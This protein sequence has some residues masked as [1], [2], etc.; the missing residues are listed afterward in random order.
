MRLLVLSF[1]LAASSIATAFVVGEPLELPLPYSDLNALYTAPRTAPVQEPCGDYGELAPRRIVESTYY[2]FCAALAE[3][4][5]TGTVIGD[6]NY[7]L[8][9]DNKEVGQP[10]YGCSVGEKIGINRIPALCFVHN[11]APLNTVYGFSGFSY[12]GK[13]PFGGKPFVV[14]AGEELSKVS[15]RSLA[16][17]EN[18][19][20]TAYQQ[21]DFQ[22]EGIE[23]TSSIS[24]TP[25]PIK[26]MKVSAI[27]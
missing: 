13:H 14:K 25:W 18:T 12:M 3:A 1:S 20:V 17:G 19:K 21:S 5:K 10:V 26:S 7:Y 15:V 27:K 2:D 8:L 22:G 16:L 4:R 9:A 24:F 6:T 11:K 23:I